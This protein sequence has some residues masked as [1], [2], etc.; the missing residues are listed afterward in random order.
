MG[1]GA[2]YTGKAALVTGAS[3][4]IGRATAKALGREGA[5]VVCAGRR[6][7]RLNETVEAIRASGGEAL[8]ASGD[9]REEA[10]CARWV[11]TARERF[12]GCADSSQ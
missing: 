7:D 8:A 11:A 9:V 2:R 1:P 12:G 3:S 4:G 10:V 5:R 6:A